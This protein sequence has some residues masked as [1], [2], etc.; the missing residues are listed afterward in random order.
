MPIGFFVAC[1]KEWKS[2][3]RRTG[4]S[5][6]NKFEQ[7]TEQ[8]KPATIARASR[9]EQAFFS[10]GYWDEFRDRIRSREFLSEVNEVTVNLAK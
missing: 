9:L 8:T 2:R 6:I 7:N 4:L 3:C 5:Q 10:G 1:H